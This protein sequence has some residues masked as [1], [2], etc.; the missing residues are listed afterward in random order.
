MPKRLLVHFTH[1]N[2]SFFKIL[3]IMLLIAITVYMVY[4]TGG[5]E[6]AFT[7]IMYIPI[8][9]AGF[10][11]GIKGAMGAALLGGYSLGPFMYK[12]VA[13]GIPQDLSGWVFRTTIFVVIGIVIG[14]LFQYVKTSKKKAIEKS[15]KNEMTGLPNLNKLKMDIDE[16]IVMQESFS[17]IAFEI[18]NLGDI[19]RYIDYQ[20]G[21]QALLHLSKVLANFVDQ[22]QVYSIHT[23]QLA[24]VVPG[25]QIE[26]TYLIGEQII[27]SFREPILIDGLLVEMMVK[28]GLVHFPLHGNDFNDLYRK[29]SIAMDQKSDTTGIF[30]YDPSKEQKN[31]ERLDI[32]VLLYDAIKNKKF[33]IV[34]QPQISLKNNQVIGVEALLRLSRG[35]KGSI[36]PEEFIKV[37]EEVGIISEITKMVVKKTIAQLKEWQEEGFITKMAINI[38]PK[39]LRNNALLEYTKEQLNTY[40]IDPSQLEFEL[41]ERGIV[42]NEHVAEQL[43]MDA[44]KLGVKISLDDFGTGYN[45]LMNLIKLPIDNIKIH[46]YFVD[47]LV[48]KE[49]QALVESMIRTMHSLNKEVIAEGVETEE[50]V[51]ILSKLG[52]DHIQGYYY[53]RPL[54][55]E[56]VKSLLG[57]DP[58]QVNA[59]KQRGTDPLWL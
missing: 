29:L 35:R 6:L 18:T 2:R 44:R 38:S 37:A 48:E 55:P 21:E 9:L 40:C 20:I 27:K 54:P 15:L 14:I 45:S 52:C 42:E 36:S 46:K 8:I 1:L 34:Y 26:A 13:E 17:L 33:N 58:H 4:I 59:L 12:N 53:S 22:E 3:L 16:R 23:N 50:Q 31:K 41:T 7:H 49:N 32:T 25:E 11:G 24:I 57:S 5:T 10:F 28:A 56:E 51:R 39:D 47:R 30:L 19:N 43:L